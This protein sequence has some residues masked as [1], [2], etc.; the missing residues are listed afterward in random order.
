METFK[1]AVAS[2]DWSKSFYQILTNEPGK[3]AWLVVGATFVLLHPAHRKPEVGKETL[4]F[5]DASRKCQ[6]PDEPPHSLFTRC[7]RH[8]GKPGRHARTPDQS[9]PQTGILFVTTVVPVIVTL[10]ISKRC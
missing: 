3:Q 7:S 5:F 8:P 4:R 1:A 2:V 6:A 9:V 10:L